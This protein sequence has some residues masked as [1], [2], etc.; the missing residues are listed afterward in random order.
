MKSFF[1]T[2]HL[3]L[4][5]AAG[6]IIFLSCLTGTIMVFEEEIEHAASPQ[7]YTAKPLGQRL[8]VSALLKNTK[9]LVPEGRPLFVKVYN[10]PARTAEIGLATKKKEN[11]G[12][13][14]KREE[15][16]AR[17]NEGKGNKKRPER[18]DVM[19]YANPYTGKIVINKSTFFHDTEMLHRFLLDKKDTPGNYIVKF[20]TLLFL[21]ILITGV[22]LWWPKTKAIMR[23]RLKI[24]FS[25]GW[26]RL[27]HDL[28][29]VMGFYTSVFLLI[30]VFTGLIMSFEWANDAIYNL[31]GTNK[32]ESVKPPVSDFTPGAKKVKPDAVYATISNY[33]KDAE[34]YQIRMP[35]DSSGVF[36]IN[37][38]PK[39]AVETTTDTYYIDQY[40]GKLKG[41]YLFAEKNAGQQIRAF[42]KPI[43]T[44]S[45]YGLPTKIISFIVCLLSLTFPVT[46]VIMWINR[47]KIKNKMKAK[48]KKRML[49]Q[50]A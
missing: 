19:A 5:L 49:A 32:E 23:Q 6:I 50:P 16:G 11:A 20:S 35:R 48:N 31:T 39:G 8:P 9:E 10:D 12:G 7:V 21:L 36:S 27:N 46:G 38:L 37:V 24:K 30:I 43:H 15:K 40:S 33:I 44:G 29:I 26:K 4:S 22:V 41:N 42:I 2:I 28:H 34:F 47:L 1:R 17:G 14:K 25:G 18:P 45:I 3:Y 13:E